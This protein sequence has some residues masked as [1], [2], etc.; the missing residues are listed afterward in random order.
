MILF[1]LVF[2]PTAVAQWLWCSAEHK[3]AGI[4]T[5]HSGCIL[6]GV[7]C[8]DACV[9]WLGCTLKKLNVVKVYEEPLANHRP[10]VAMT[11]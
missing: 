11:C 8:K 7:E 3:V 5:A 2:L 1:Q 6:L 10:C 9:P 4:I